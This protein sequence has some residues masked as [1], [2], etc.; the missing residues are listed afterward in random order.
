VFG[1]HYEIQRADGPG[2]SSATTVWSGGGSS[3]KVGPFPAGSQVWFRVRVRAVGD[4]D[5]GPWSAAVS[6]EF[7]KDE[8]APS[9][10][11]SP[12]K[13]GRVPEK[14]EVS[15]VTEKAP[16]PPDDPAPPAADPEPEKAPVKPD[17]PAPE[18]PKDS[19]PADAPAE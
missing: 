1:E 9:P 5:P 19:A 15:A 14:D 16:A 13:D 10:P 17:P 4:G 2:F 7:P 12:E 8:K 6:V 11:A 18:P 3:A